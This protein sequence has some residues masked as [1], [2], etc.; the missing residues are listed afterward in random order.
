MK[1]ITPHLVPCRIQQRDHWESVSEYS[2]LGTAP[3]V[4]YVLTGGRKDM[5]GYFFY[6]GP[7][8]KS[9]RDFNGAMLRGPHVAFLEVARSMVFQRPA[10]GDKVPDST[11]V[12]TFGD[13][14]VFH[15]QPMRLDQDLLT[16]RYV[17]S[18]S[19]TLGQKLTLEIGI[20]PAEFTDGV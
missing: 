6:V 7:A 4:E 18:D 1:T 11:E 3:W 10:P 20:E 8:G 2:G 19:D 12:L 17:W 16:G 13:I 5:H 14:V 9:V 15:G